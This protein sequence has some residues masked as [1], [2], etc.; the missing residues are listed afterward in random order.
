[1]HTYILLVIGVNR[2]TEKGEKHCRSPGIESLLSYPIISLHTPG[3]ESLES[4]I[5]Y[6]VT[7]CCS[8]EI[9]SR[10]MQQ[11]H[12]MKSTRFFDPRRSYYN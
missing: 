10:S 7:A 4:T 1:M 3:H 9:S 12:N 6:C 11:Q 5:Y 2:L 8:A